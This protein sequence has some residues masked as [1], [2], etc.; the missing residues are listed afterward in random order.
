[1]SDK[2]ILFIHHGTVIGGAPTSLR[3]T[4]LGLK[5]VGFTNLKVLCLYPPMR[6]FFASAA[7]PTDVMHNAPPQIVGR[8]LIGWYQFGLRFLYGVAREFLAWRFYLEL[9]Y[10]L[11]TER[12]DIVHL[13]SSILLSTALIAK[14]LGLT[15]VWHVREYLQGGDWNLKKR[16]AGWL[17]RRLADQVI[18]ISET[19]AASLGTD[20][21]D[22]IRVVYNFVDLYRFQ[23]DK[24]RSKSF[25]E[26]LA[27]NEGCFVVASLGGISQHKGIDQLLEALLYTPKH[28]HLVVAGSELIEKQATIKGWRFL[29]WSVEDALVRWGWKSRRQWFYE[30]RVER[31]YNQLGD[32]QHRVHFLGVL[33]DVVPLLDAC[34]LL[35]F[36]GT[37]PHFPR[38]VF[39]A[40]AMGKSVLVFDMLGISDHVQ[41]GVNGYVAPMYRPN[42]LAEKL[43]LVADA[44][45]LQELGRNGQLK[46]QQQFSAEK[47]IAK[48][49]QIYD[50]L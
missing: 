41:E 47:N 26:E 15:V 2:K 33:E 42:L 49:V 25:R 8:F 38:P 10:K 16:F 22:N 34:D 50:C 19:E 12:P 45:D 31:I 9:R 3:N 40:W 36:A 27:L 24:G 6:E 14:S 35:I 39:E 37:M 23:P 44:K 5:Q 13:N 1:M 48:L 4:L 20:T 17:I 32:A 11:K 30:Q 7:V 29:F 46:A 18:C 43:T 28:L 21:Y